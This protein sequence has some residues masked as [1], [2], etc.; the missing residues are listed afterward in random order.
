MAVCSTCLCVL[1]LRHAA[2]AATDAGSRGSAC[3]LLDHFN[4]VAHPT[5][6][7]FFSCCTKP[8]PECNDFHVLVEDSW[9]DFHGLYDPFRLH[10]QGMGQLDISL[11]FF[12][13]YTLKPD[14]T[15][16]SLYCCWSLYP[17]PWTVHKL[18]ASHLAWT[19]GSV[20]LVYAMADL[21]VHHVQ[22]KI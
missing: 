2:T 7:A 1:I 15:I 18:L 9:M 12:S 13:I 14:E 20:S 5:D 3:K 6:A 4:R 17:W 16:Q 22:D 10:S 19:K 11:F 8:S 21:L